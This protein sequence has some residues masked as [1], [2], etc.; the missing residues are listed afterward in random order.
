LIICSM[1]AGGPGA[2]QRQPVMPNVLPK[3]RNTTVFS[4]ACLSGVGLCPS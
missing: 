2:A 4:G 1:I 3:P